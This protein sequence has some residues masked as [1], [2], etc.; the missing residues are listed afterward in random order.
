M[1]LMLNYVPRKL[2]FMQRRR[3]CVYDL[4]ASTLGRNPFI[5]FGEHFIAPLP[6]T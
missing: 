2:I 4:R 6:A 3:V 1:K 5:A